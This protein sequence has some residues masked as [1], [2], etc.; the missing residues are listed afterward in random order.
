MQQC[1]CTPRNLLSWGAPLPHPNTNLL[2]MSAVWVVSKQDGRG[3]LKMVMSQVTQAL[4]LLG[5]DWHPQSSCHS[6]TIFFSFGLTIDRLWTAATDSIHSPPWWLVISLPAYM[7]ASGGILNKK[8]VPLFYWHCPLFFHARWLI[9]VPWL[10][11]HSCFTYAALLCSCES[12]QSYRLLPCMTYGLLPWM[13]SGQIGTLTSVLIQT[14][15]GT[16][17]LPAAVPSIPP[18][19]YMDSNDFLHIQIAK[20]L[21]SLHLLL[22][23]CINQSRQWMGPSKRQKLKT[24]PKVT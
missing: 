22:I 21:S 14:A 11:A 4:L 18:D 9:L 8:W 6:S 1:Y 7:P 15:T 5:L 17:W 23:I 16:T 24:V 10:W 19:Q 20:C 2:H 3:S 12:L 13:T